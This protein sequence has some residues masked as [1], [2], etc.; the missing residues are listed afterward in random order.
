MDKDEEKVGGQMIED[1]VLGFIM[2]VIVVTAVV[3]VTLAFFNPGNNYTVIG[4]LG[5][6]GKIGDYPSNLKVNQSVT[7]YLFIYNHE[8]KAMYYVIYEKLGN[9]STVLNSTYPGYNLPVL[10]VYQVIVGND[11]NVTLPVVIKIP[12]PIID[13]KVFF[14]LY[15]YNGSEVYSGEWLQL[16]LNVTE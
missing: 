11:E 5:I 16:I 4:L 14:V 2:A 7:L 12:Y 13:G 6:N 8:G 1:E 15:Y 3:A 10:N 9:Y